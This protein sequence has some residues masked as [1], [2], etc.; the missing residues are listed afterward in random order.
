M[1][2]LAVKVPTH[3]VI[4]MIENKLVQID[5]AIANYPALIQAYKQAQVDYQKSLVALTIDALT[6][7]PE[8]IGENHNDPIRVYVNNYSGRSVNV[9]IDSDALGFPKPP[10]E[11]ENP[12]NKEYVGREYVSKRE[13]LA[14]T[15]RTLRMTEQETINAS[16]YANVMKF[17]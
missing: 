13:I 1:A 5:E 2:S 10:V 16:T 15:L 14:N 6:K 4:E 9:Q 11:P 8:L 7:K 12:D 3:K 17:L